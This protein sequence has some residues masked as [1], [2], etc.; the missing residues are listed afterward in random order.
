MTRLLVML[1]ALKTWAPIKEESGQAAL[2]I[3]TTVVIAAGVAISQT[4][5]M[6]S[7]RGLQV[8]QSLRANFDLVQAAIEVYAIQ[9]TGSGS[10]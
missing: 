10:S 8:E 9:D 1:R 4:S 2:V 6:N 5:L 3:I 7:K